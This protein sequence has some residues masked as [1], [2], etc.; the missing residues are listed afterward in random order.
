MVGSSCTKQVYYMFNSGELIRIGTEQLQKQQV[1]IYLFYC[2]F[3]FLSGA[4]FLKLIQLL[5]ISIQFL[6]E[7]CTKYFFRLAVSTRFQ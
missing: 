6:I 7:L 2:F 1:F 4:I 3:M 5:F